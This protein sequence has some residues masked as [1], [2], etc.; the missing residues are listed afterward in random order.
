MSLLDSEIGMWQ[1]GRGMTRYCHGT[2][3]HMCSL[4]RAHQV[5]WCTAPVAGVRAACIYFDFCV[6]AM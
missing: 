1:E 3:L 6:C 4:L 5:N 2:P